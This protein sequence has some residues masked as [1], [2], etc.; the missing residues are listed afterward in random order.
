MHAEKCIEVKP[1]QYA[2]LGCSD[3]CTGHDL[4]SILTASGLSYGACLSG[5]DDTCQYCAELRWANV[6]TASA[7]HLLL[8]GLCC[9]L[10]ATLASCASQVRVAVKCDGTK[11]VPL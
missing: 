8:D 1:S 4:S 11:T 6:M 7:M 10:V 9:G 2:F 5:T 3:Q